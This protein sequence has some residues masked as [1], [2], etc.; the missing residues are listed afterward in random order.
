MWAPPERLDEWRAEQANPAAFGLFP[1]DASWMKDIEQVFQL[2]HAWRGRTDV[3]IY[4]AADM[5]PGPVTSLESDLLLE[6]MTTNVGGALTS[7]HQVLPD[8]RRHG[9][10]TILFT[11]GGLALEPYPGWAALAAGKA[12]LRSVALNLH[13]ELLPPGIHVA[14]VAVCGILQA[15]T[16]FAPEA[17]AEEYWRLHAQPIDE[18]ERELVYL[19]QGADPYYNDPHDRHRTTSQPISPQHR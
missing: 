3:L 14:V 8:M 10:G 12:A 6:T 11:G 2:I 13:R 4:N 18:S 7:V 17:V 1:A 5:A 19:P 16:A 15:G 9:C